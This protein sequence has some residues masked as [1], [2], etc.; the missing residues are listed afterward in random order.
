MNGGHL[1][2]LS[3]S[4]F[5]KNHR[6]VGNSP[7]FCHRYPLVKKP[8]GQPAAEHINRNVLFLFMKSVAIL[9]QRMHKF[10]I[11]PSRKQAAR[12]LCQFDACKTIYN[13]LLAL[14]RDAYKFGRVFLGK[15][16]YNI[17][18]K[19][20]CFDVHSQILQNVSD[21]V[22]KAFANFFRRVKEKKL[23]KKVRVGFPR[24][25]K[26]AKSITFPQSGFRIISG[27]R[28]RLSKVGAVPIVLHRIPKGKIKTLTIKR[29]QAGQWFAI[30][31]CEISIS[32]ISE[33][34]D[35]APAIGIDIGLET[36]ATLSNGGT[37]ANPRF[38]VASQEK[39]A[40]LQR[41][42]S[43]K[44]R[45]SKN[46]MKARFKAARM[47][48]KIA[49]QRSDFLHKLSRSLSLRFGTIVVE[50]LSICNMIKN[51]H[52]AKS[53]SDASW[54]KFIQMLSYKAESAGGKVICVNPRGTTVK[55]SGC[56]SAVPKSLGIRRH[57]CPFCGLSLHRDHNSAINILS[58]AGLAGTDACRD[59][60]STSCASKRQAE[61]LKQ[62]LYA[63]SP[64][65]KISGQ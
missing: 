55:C 7:E 24:Y 61:S 18:L 43:R 4:V 23:G 10:R 30:F 28:L 3:V 17:F 53:I 25:K 60:A 57:L 52:L 22:S 6:T 34:K 37:I 54:E 31:S 29:N 9:V 65:E 50:K 13:E 46:R 40:M 48:N 16:D 42:L 49:N 12:L 45:G 63:V 32:G 58:T 27:K 56:G 33:R 1:F 8:T 21:R 64:E 38:F 2:L 19:G 15:F 44:A 51:H 41:R 39:I 36:F 26:F 5:R 14:S 11:Y 35:V 20:K 47:H 62:E 59:F